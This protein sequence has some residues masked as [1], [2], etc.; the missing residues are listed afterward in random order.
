MNIK[1]EIKNIKDKEV[2][3][4]LLES[5]D[6]YVVGRNIENSGSNET[7]NISVEKANEIMNNYII[8][9]DY[10]N[11][12]DEFYFNYG[13]EYVI[14]DLNA[15][16]ISEIL[17]QSDFDA[18]FYYTW[19]FA[20]EGENVVLVNENYGYGKHRY[21]PKHNAILV[22]P[23]TK[24]FSGTGATPFYKLEG[25][26]LKKAFVVGEDVG[27]AFYSDDSG[28]KSITQEECSVYFEDVVDFEFQ[29]LN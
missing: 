29:K 6:G 24:P 21:S 17:I 2:K 20:L 14:K 25:T 28:R 15:D 11:S 18:P 13:L 9:E 1:Y 23:E 16:G 22:S 27:N 19:L 3:N 12:I 10:K 5:Y 7:I 4:C 8:S 26:V